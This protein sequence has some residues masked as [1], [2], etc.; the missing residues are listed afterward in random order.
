MSTHNIC[1][2]IVKLRK[3]FPQ[4]YYQVLLLNKSSV[5]HWLLT[6]KCLFLQ[7]IPKIPS[8]QSCAKVC[9]VVCY[10][11]INPYPAIHDSL[12]LCK[13][14]SSR[15]WSHLIRI[16]TVCHS[17]CE[18]ERKHKL[19]SRIRVEYWKF[20]PHHGKK[21]HGIRSRSDCTAMQYG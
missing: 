9:K 8:A 15:W 17:V 20:E 1:F 4:N 19:F 14:C 13:Q 11:F 12:Y 3:L 7:E 18:F 2:F 21:D 5:Y 6:L 16:C 10:Y